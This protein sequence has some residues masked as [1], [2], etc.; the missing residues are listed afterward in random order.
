MVV[1]SPGL[2]FGGVAKSALWVRGNTRV[3]KD[4]RE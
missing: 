1:A 3:E 2:W 4:V